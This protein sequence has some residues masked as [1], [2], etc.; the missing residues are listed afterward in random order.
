MNSL[1]VK[2]YVPHPLN[3]EMSV[4]DYRLTSILVPAINMGTVVGIIF[5]RMFNS[6][7]ALLGLMFFLILSFATTAQK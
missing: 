5:A 3:H 1:Y 2:Y 7:T 4:T 6:I